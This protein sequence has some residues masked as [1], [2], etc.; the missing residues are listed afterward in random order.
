M[1]SYRDEYTINPE[2][3]RKI[4][5]G[6]Q[7]CKRLAAKYYMIDEEFSDQL[8]PDSRAYVTNKVLGVILNEKT[9]K[10]LQAIPLERVGYP[11]GEHM[12]LIV[13]STA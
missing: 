2:T 7:T 4:N 10:S 1:D 8:F 11:R 6:T 5:V 12:Y 3:G 13:G 9:Y